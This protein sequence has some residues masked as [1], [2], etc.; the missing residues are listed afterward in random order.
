MD[1]VSYLPVSGSAGCSCS[2]GCVCQDK[3]H[4][5][6]I[7][8]SHAISKCLGWQRLL[9]YQAGTDLAQHLEKSRSEAENLPPL[10]RTAPQQT[11]PGDMLSV[12]Q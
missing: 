10:P 4:L 9:L 5:P 3:K 8:N 6:D 7:L 11:G 2:S 1:S 12:S